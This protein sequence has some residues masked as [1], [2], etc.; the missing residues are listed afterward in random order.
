MLRAPSRILAAVLLTCV[1]A[2]CAVGP[3]YK[4]PAVDA[5]Q[6]YRDAPSE[7]SATASFGEEKWSDVF[8]DP[9]LQ[10]LIHTALQQNY[11]VRIAAARI[12]EAQAQLGI[13]RSNELPSAAVIL[14]SNGNRN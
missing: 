9:P 6:K 3:N 4:R 2:G 1:L 11:D 5:P 13:T 10:A 14:D 7:T 12:A 8:Q